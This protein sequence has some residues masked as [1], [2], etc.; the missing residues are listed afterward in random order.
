MPSGTLGRASHSTT[1]RSVFSAGEMLV[2]HRQR[3]ILGN[4]P[5]APKKEEPPRTL[6]PLQSIIASDIFSP[7][8]CRL[9]TKQSV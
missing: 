1:L 9:A 3:G 2:L 7:F 5:P 6:A 4:L 8:S